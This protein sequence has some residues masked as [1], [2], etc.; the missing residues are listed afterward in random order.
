[1]RSPF[2]FS[3]PT[4]L[5]LT[6]SALLGAHGAV[7][8]R[9]EV[10]RVAAAIASR[11]P[12]EAPPPA[13]AAK[14]APPP[15]LQP[16]GEPLSA[17]KI[18]QDLAAG[19]SVDLQGRI[20]DGSLDADAVGVASDEHRTSLRIVPGR[21]RLDACRI[22]GRV[23]MPRAVLAQDVVITCSEIVGDVELSDAMVP[24]L[25]LD[26]TKVLGDVHLARTIVDREVTL[27]GAT[28][29]GSFDASGG[30]TGGIVMP[31][32]EVHRDVEI[33]HE[34][35][36]SL[37]MT[38]ALVNGS[39]KLD[40][41]LI[42]NS[43]TAHEAKIGR[44][45]TFDTVRIA[46]GMDLNDLAPTGGLS[47]VNLTVEGSLMLSI[48]GDFAVAFQDIVVGQKLVMVDGEFGDVNLERMRVRMGSEMQGSRFRK[49]LIVGDT[50]FGSLFSASQA[51]FEGQ[52]EF[53]NVRFAGQ[54][55][56]AGAVFASAPV[57]V[58]TVLPVPPVL[59]GDE[60]A[61]GESNEGD[62]GG[63]EPDPKP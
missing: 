55:P 12:K 34:V 11:P 48:S 46:G 17:Q 1:M 30:R 2:S 28:V 20:I 43:L 56:M 15:C 4:V 60:G 37:E 35:I 13:P 27:R 47:A 41:V 25:M 57:L 40:D 21:L 14:P 8:A 52:T 45:M 19:R 7:H 54:D 58:D 50:D 38:T 59:M 32:A 29:E 44:A 51:R 6:V 53:Q 49:K 24:A 22:N 16:Q 5:A 61:N 3:S 62:D 42:V 36:Q 39:V 63:E 9:S 10:E 26:R 33:S 23:M 18:M 31:G